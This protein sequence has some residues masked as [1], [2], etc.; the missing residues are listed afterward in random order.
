MVKSLL[1][2]KILVIRFSSLGDV[3]LTTALLPNLKAHWPSAEVTVLTR[4]EN[5]SLFDGN[6]HVNRVFVFNP[7]KQSFYDLS[8]EVRR[9]AFDV[10]FDLQGNMRSAFICLIAAA[11]RVVIAKKLTWARRRL[12][13]FKRPSPSLD[14]SVRERVLDCLAPFGIP[15]PST[16]TQ[17][18]PPKDTL[19]VL[20]TFSIDPGKTL[21]GIAPGAK[22]NTKRWKPERFAEAANRLGAVANSL[23]LILG[24]K[25]DRT[26]A[27]QVASLVRVPFKNMA[28]WTSLPEIMA[29]MSRLSLLLTN[30]SGLL[31]MA[32]ALKV[33]VVAIFGPTVRA[34]GFAPYRVTSRVVEVTNLPCRPCTLH[35]SE[36]CPLG[37]HKCMEDVDLEAVLYAASSTGTLLESAP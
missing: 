30:D 15:A 19:G 8:R 36:Q 13:L 37:H 12:V 5:A 32:E 17:L 28:G 22:H 21:I 31:H 27:D 3:V 33:P 4:H 9:E 14:R 23:I 35:G 26:V 7:A 10:V 20:N 6:P 18:Y 16:E 24:D 2:R 11:P 25:Q 1:P 34:F 29:I